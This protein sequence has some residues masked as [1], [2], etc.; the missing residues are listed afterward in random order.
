M[1]NIRRRRFI[2]QGGIF[3]KPRTWL[4]DVRN[5][6]LAGLRSTELK[7]RLINELDYMM[8][9]YSEQRERVEKS[10]EFLSQQRGH[11]GGG[12]SVPSYGSGIYLCALLHRCRCGGTTR[13]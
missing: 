4:R 1:F 7:T 12:E 13:C 10:L 5:I 6:G 9:Q 11:A 3:S 2:E 8:V